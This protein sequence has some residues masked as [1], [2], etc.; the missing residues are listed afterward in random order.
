MAA[1]PSDPHDEVDGGHWRLRA[2]LLALWAA[3]SFG[4]AFFARDLDQVLGGWPVN[5]W[6]AAQGAVLVFLGIVGFFAWW[7]NRRAAPAASAPA[8]EED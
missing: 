6:L 8:A 3:S 7:A 4:V 1:P 2:A 5:Y